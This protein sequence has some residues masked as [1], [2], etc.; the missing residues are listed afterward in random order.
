[1]TQTFQCWNGPKQGHTVTEVPMVVTVGHACALPWQTVRGVERYAVYI[2]LEKM[3]G[4]RGL[5][6]DRS[7]DKPFQAQQRVNQIASAVQP[8]H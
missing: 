3:N 2:L 5:V 4:Q 6:Y 7:Y 8:V 1:M